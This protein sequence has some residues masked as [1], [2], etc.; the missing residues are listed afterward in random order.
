MKMI[1]LTPQ[2]LSVNFATKFDV[3][4]NVTHL[5]INSYINT[6]C[7]Y[8][9]PL[10]LISLSVDNEF[11]QSIPNLPHLKIFIIGN[12]F[13]QPVDKLLPKLTHLT[14]REKFNQPVDKLSI[15]L[16]HLTTG[17]EFNQPVAKLP[18]TLTHLKTGCKF[19]QPVH[20]LPPTLTHLTTGLNS[21]N[22]SVIFY[23]HSLT[24]QLD[25]FSTNQ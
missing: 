5:K 2:K 23:P 14:T 10:T 9:F 4:S 11:N 20:T 25:I 19:N 24:L 21:T 7:L 18:P 12:N 15:T 1:T 6:T 3:S 8:T 16:T 17:Y 13:N 22:Q